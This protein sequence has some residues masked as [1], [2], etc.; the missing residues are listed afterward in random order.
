MDK[1][2]MGMR[3]LISLIREMIFENY[4]IHHFE[5]FDFPY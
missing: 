5:N 1:Y 3:N 4:K 2:F